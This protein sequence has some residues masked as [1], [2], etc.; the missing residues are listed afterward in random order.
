MADKL[1]VYNGA[2]FKIKQ[3]KIASLTS[4]DPSRYLIDEV[5][6]KVLLFMLEA[7]AWNFAQRTVAVDAAT[8]VEPGFGWSNAFE[9]PDD[10]VRIIAISTN[11]LLYPPMTANQYSFENDYWMANASVL[12]VAYV[13]NDSDFGL[14]LNKWTASFTEAVE[15]ELADRIAP[16]LT[17]M[18]GDEAERLA[19]RKR[20]ALRNARTKDAYNQAGQMQPPGALSQSRRNFRNNTLWNR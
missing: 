18:G 1:S 17:N 16:P 7:G 4:T 14:N 19:A 10:F 11:P 5:Y 13:S 3:R 9:V 15:Y 2:L 20:T 12:Y 8:D 6:D